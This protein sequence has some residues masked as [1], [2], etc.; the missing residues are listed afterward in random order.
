[1]QTCFFVLSAALPSRSSASSHRRFH[2]E[3]L[4]HAGRRAGRPE[5][6]RGPR[7]GR[8]AL[9]LLA[10]VRRSDSGRRR[11]PPVPVEAPDFVQRV[12]AMILAGKGDLLP[13][14]AF[15]VDGTWPVGTARFEKRNLA[16]EIPVWDAPLCI[17]CNKCA[18]VCPHAAI[19][20]KVYDAESSTHAPSTFKSTQWK[21]GEFA[22]KSYTL[23]V[24]PEDCTGCGVCVAVCP[25]KDKS[26]PRHKA[27]DM[28][29]QAPLRA[30]ERE[31]YDF[32]LQLPEVQRQSVKLDVKESQL[33]EPLFEYSGACSGCGE[34]PYVK[35]LTQ[36]FGD[37]LLIANATGCSSIYG[38][39][40]PTTPYTTNR[41]GRGPAWS[42]SLFEDNAEFGFG[43]RLSVDYLRE[44][45]QHLVRCSRERHWRGA[46]PGI[47][48]A[49]QVN[50][51]TGILDQT[52]PSPSAACTQ[53]GLAKLPRR[54]AAES[55]RRL[56]R[57]KERLD[58]RRRRLGLRHWIWRSRPR[59]GVGQER[60]RARARHRGL[61]QHRRPTVQGDA[62]GRV[63]QVRVQRQVHRKEGPWPD[64][65]ELR[66]RLRGTRR[67]RGQGRPD[68]ARLRR[69][70]GPRRA[71][72]HHRL[73]PL[74]RS[75]LRFGPRP[76]AA[77][78][79]GRVRG[80]EPLPL[81][82][83]AHGSRRPAIAAGLGA[84][85]GQPARVRPKRG[86]LQHG[87]ARQPDTLRQADEGGG[88]GRQAT[89][90]AVRRARALLAAH[91]E[92]AWIF[93]L[94]TWV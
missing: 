40:L 42:N 22:G 69:G 39:N 56:P 36:L 64:R 13:V 82:S 14:S 44:R 91:G 58:R 2:Q 5:R 12:S 61:F 6:G 74:H 23:Q 75:R 85:Q 78:A 63:G 24:A 84:P 21:S 19:R 15:P 47:L 92:M 30:V 25:A 57:R 72:D 38:G 32:F 35:L 4:R 28:A 60:Q 33:L 79:R 1:M 10:S 77:E 41:D 48:D 83:S 68:S 51:E 90:G 7:R 49:R 71:F 73:Q 86:A 31:N 93:R 46:S 62:A 18:M 89:P 37:R 20:A 45:A 53:A 27:I 43:M 87:G 55:G 81:R 11:T 50:D 88:A 70:R 80:V 76:T 26:N 66:S 9:A 29:P 16:Q 3:E 54:P 34:T 52:G 59:P 67:L 17:Q 65:H 8:P 94:A